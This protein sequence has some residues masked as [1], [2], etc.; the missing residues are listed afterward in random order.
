MISRA[1]LAAG[2]LASSLFAAPPLT[3]IQDVLYKADGTRFNGSLTISWTSFEAIDR[4][5]I[6]QQTTTVV[7]VD[8]NLRVQL[9]P[10]T[11][12]NPPAAYTV[13]YSSDGRIQFSEN[14]AVPSSAQPLRVREV[15]VANVSLVSSDSA[16][17]TVNESDVVGLISD[18]GARP[19]KGPG[20]AAG[21]VAWVN[22]TG[23]METV[24]GA[25]TD[26]VRVDGSS[27]PC[28]GTPP[29]FVDN[30]APTGLV[31]GANVNFALTG[32]PNPS[33]S[34]AVY[35]NGI[36]LKVGQDFTLNG[37]AV[38][39]VSGAAPQPGDTLLA[40]Y[41]LTGTDPGTPQFYPAPQVL[42]SGTG[43]AANATALASI[44][45]CTIPGG[46]LAPGDR[47]EVH[48]DLEHTGSTGGFSFE[49]HWGGT[50]VLHRDGAPS[51]VLAAIRA[52]AAVTAAGVQLSHQ[53]WGTALAFAAGIGAAADDVSG[54]ITIDLQAKVVQTSDTIAL[55][56]YTVM[57][58]R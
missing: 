23:A 22:P 42:C 1:I 58:H 51:D 40:S 13:K 49:L 47:V 10:T 6:A 45:A 18:L 46:L 53:S 19:L 9:V 33:T 30:D 35:R 25:P 55:K 48:L 21:R 14:W 24:T 34:L 29:S 50:T 39:F 52:D 32:V 31:D 37:N 44:G 20:Y 27:G 38:Q 36:L 2:F 8:G 54:G 3:T 57:K 28:G 4:S 16:P 11:T 5:A 26:C 17:T 56:N 12:A 41:R 7:V 15:R 43:S